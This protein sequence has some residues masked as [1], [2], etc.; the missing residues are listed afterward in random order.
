MQFVVIGGGIVG[1]SVAYHLSRDGHAVTLYE[2][3]TVG[4]AC[5]GMSAGTVAVTHTRGAAASTRALYRRLERAGHDVG[6]HQTGALYVATT[7]YEWLYGTLRFRKHNAVTPVSKAD[8]ALYEPCL[9]NASI[10][11]AFWAPLSGWVE[12]IAATVALAEAASEH[13]ARVLEGT[14][15]PPQIPAGTVVVEAVGADAA[16]VQS[17][18]GVMWHMPT[19]PLKRVL[20]GLGLATHWVGSGKAPLSQGG[21]PY[22]LY[23]RPD[24]DEGAWVGGPRVWNPSAYEDEARRHQLATRSAMGW[25]CVG[26]PW[27]SGQMPFGRLTVAPLPDGR[28]IANGFGAHGVTLAPAL[29]ERIASKYRPVRS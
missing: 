27:V 26:M 13:G 28:W 11:G 6:W 3:D 17:V 5:T 16:D 15:A 18:G 12:P 23:A 1:A 24:T 4:H 20:F 10:V 22:H 21:V 25:A 29:T 8:A 14:A 7:P 2:R 9:R 19:L